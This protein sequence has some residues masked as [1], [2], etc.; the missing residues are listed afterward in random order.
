L[1]VGDHNRGYLYFYCFI[2][3]TDSGRRAQSLYFA[4]GLAE[5]RNKAIAPYGSEQAAERT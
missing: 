5:R 3:R 4:N 1:L 2:K